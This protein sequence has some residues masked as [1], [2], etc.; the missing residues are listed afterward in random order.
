MSMRLIPFR[1]A[2]ITM[3]CAGGVAAAEAQDLEPRAYTAAPV[4]TTF[5]GVGVGRSSGS[6]LLDPSLPI[7]D[8][9]ARLGVVS[10]AVGHTFDFFGRTALV[11]GTVPFARARAEGQIGE[12]TRAATRTGLADA[13]MRMSV[14]L[15]G[16]RALRL[17]EFAKT[18]R[19]TIVGVSMTAVAPTGQYDRT[20]LV[21][22][23]SNRWSF[24]P[25]V[26]VSVPVGRWS[27]EGYAGV[28]LFGTNDRFYPGESVR[29]QDRVVALQTH[30]GYTIRP[31]LWAAVNGTWYSGGTTTVDGVDKAD[32]Q[33]N[34]RAGVTV[35]VPF[36]RRHSV[37][38]NYSTGTTTR[39]GGDFNTVAAAWQIT[40]LRQ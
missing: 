2:V 35:S 26:G 38:V 23:G 21:N 25:E 33:R 34:T 20:R 28:W 19:T 1:V 13:R 5:A 32:L 36:A 31:G 11:L 8:V 37:K 14:N 10:G 4:S 27:V 24:K 17:R 18:P 30:V 16:G 29:T 3:L 40:W 6:V 7:E 12:S 22:L 39:I 9:R 15:L